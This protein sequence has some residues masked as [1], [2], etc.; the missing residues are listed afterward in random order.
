[1]SDEPSQPRRR[2]KTRKAATSAEAEPR[3]ARELLSFE[4]A[5]TAL[6]SIVRALEQGELGLS[7]SLA[8]YEQGVKYLK[9][10]YGQLATAERRIELLKQVDS[11]G[12][13]LTEPFDETTMSLEEKAAARGARRSVERGRRGKLGQP[14]RDDAVDDSAEL[15]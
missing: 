6:E 4:D 14:A 13:A 15:F 10:C 3:D 1:M 7:D 11:Q 2:K 12:Q 9:Q 8:Q 5:L